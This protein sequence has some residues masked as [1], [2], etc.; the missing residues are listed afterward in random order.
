MSE[1]V[2]QR[3]HEFVESQDPTILSA[4]IADDAVFH[5]P[6]VHTPQVG[7]QMCMMYLMGAMQVFSQG[8]FR[9]VGQWDQTNGAVLEFESEIE[10]IT[11]NGVDLIHWN[12]EGQIVEFKVMVRPLKGMQKI[13]EKMHSML[14]SMK[15]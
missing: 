7:K 12:D 9:Y 10:G 6:V 13:H 14:D 5:S 8:T 11:I 15:S 3:W 4:L 1:T 2:L